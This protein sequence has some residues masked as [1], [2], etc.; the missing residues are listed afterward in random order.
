[1]KK[2]NPPK[3]NKTE[4][5]FPFRG[6]QLLGSEGF[7]VKADQHLTAEQARFTGKLTYLGVSKRR[8]AIGMHFTDEE[9]RRIHF[10]LSSFDQLIGMMDKGV[11]T[12][13]FEPVKC[14]GSCAWRV[15]E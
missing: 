15:V 14:G 4:F 1:M 10:F 7:Y 3:A 8:S 6:R 9:G 5:L 13:T 12:G 2:R 11:L